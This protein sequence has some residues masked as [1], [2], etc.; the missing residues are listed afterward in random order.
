MGHV[1]LVVGSNTLGSYQEAEDYFNVSLSYDVWCALSVGVK[2]RSLVAAFNAM[3][4]MLW[5]GARTDSAQIAPFPRTGLTDVDGSE[6][7]S[8]SVPTI[9]KY[10]QFEF[11]AYLATNKGFVDNSKGQIK[12]VGAGSA[13]VEFFENTVQEKQSKDFPQVIEQFFSI[14]SSTSSSITVGE[15]SGTCQESFFK[16]TDYGTH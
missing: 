11:A 7:A 10:G 6:I 4:L 5:D 1:L 13:K 8:D 16:S 12:K 2:K 14:L 15:A 9:A 3:N